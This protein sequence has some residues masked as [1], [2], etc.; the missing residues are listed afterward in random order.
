MFE[1]KLLG[2]PRRQLLFDLLVR[3]HISPID[4]IDAFLNSRHHVHPDSDLIE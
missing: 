4:V 1:T 2:K 3:D